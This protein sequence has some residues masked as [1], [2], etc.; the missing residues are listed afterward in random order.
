MIANKD[1]Y[2]ALQ[3]EAAKLA[4]PQRPVWLMESVCEWVKVKERSRKEGIKVH[5]ARLFG[6]VVQKG[7]ELV[8]A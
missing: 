3:D 7:S 8:G 4:N 2:K 1:A 5:K 6:F